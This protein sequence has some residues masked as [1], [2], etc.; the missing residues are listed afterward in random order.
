MAYEFNGTNQSILATSAPGTG[1]PL[2]ISAWF[3]SDSSTTRTVIASVSGLD[4]FA[5]VQDGTKTGDPICATKYSS[6]TDTGE[7][8]S[9]TGYTVG[10]WHHGCAVFASNASRTVY[11]DGGG[12]VENTTNRPSAIN[13]TRTAI[14]A[15]ARSPLAAFFDGRVAE[16]GIWNAALTDGEVAS[17]AKAVSPRLIRPQSLVFYAPLVR[18]LM[19]LRASLALTNNNSATVT[20]HPRIYL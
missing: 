9:S 4:F 14:G 18:D 1:E 10:Q 12:K 5:L 11:L 15:L 17:L 8:V 19:D 2:T 3:V 20:N 6:G 16:V 7:A 13:I